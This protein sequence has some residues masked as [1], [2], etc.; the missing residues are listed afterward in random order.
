[1]PKPIKEALKKVRDSIL[2]ALP[3]RASL[4]LDF[5]MYQQ[6][7]LH[8]DN[9][10]TFNEKIQHR[11]LHDRNPLMT[12]LSD[13][14]LAKEYVAKALGSEWVIPTLW[15][16]TALPPRPE[17]KWQLPYVLKAS[18][19]SGW[20]L[21]IRSREDEKWGEIE[22]TTDGW[23]A[24][25]FGKP[26]WAWAYFNIQPRLLVEPFLEE[27]AADLIDY[28]FWV[29]GGKVELIQVDVDRYV[30]HKQYFYDRHWKRQ[31]F[32]YAAPGTPEDVAPPQS[33][34]KMIWA[35]ELL[36]GQFS[37]VRVDLYEVGG[38]PLFGEF[39]FY[40]NGAHSKFNPESIDAE[41]GRLWPMPQA[42][43]TT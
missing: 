19:G 30:N 41:I 27:V 14:I 29:F 17:R 12:E 21:F 15:Y 37:F 9:P 16:G 42:A 3:V 18:H 10:V 35:S 38:V 2:E 22:R 4:E 20:N 1:M 40:P 25:I 23:L 39:T 26:F 6:R 11:K 33:L 24:T 36:G 13:K 43:Q 8:L 32:E 31:A 7:L 28:K 5:F 34:E